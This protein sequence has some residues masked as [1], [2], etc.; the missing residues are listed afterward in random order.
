[1]HS[2][3]SNFERPIPS[4]SWKSILWASL[5]AT[6]AIALAW[7]LYTRSQGY[8]P[9][10]NDSFALWADEREKLEDDS[11]VLIGASRTLFNIDLE[12]LEKG[13]GRKPLQLA[14]TGSSFYPMLE[15]L[16]NDEAFKGTIIIGVVPP[17]LPVPG[18]PL[19]DR[20]KE[21]LRVWKRS[22]ISESI[23]QDIALFLEERIAFLKQEDLTLDILLGK[24]PIANRPNALIA[25]PSPPY[26]ATIERNRRYRMIDACAQPGEL[27]SQVQ[28]TWPPL[29]SP[30]PPPS[31]VDPD[32]F[33]KQMMEAGIAH[34]NNVVNLVR[35]VKDR[36]CKVVFIRHPSSD[37]LR[38]LERKGAPR[39]QIWDPLLERTQVPGIH[40]EDHEELAGF[41]C[42]EWSHLSNED[43]IEYTKRLIPHLKTALQ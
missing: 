26:F 43:S 29:F 2:S 3:T 15:D 42:P 24:L 40:F 36:G 17:M 13:L 14:F 41:P 37:L 9:T 35:R 11:L 25:P 7:E 38:E 27:Q 23:G 10:L 18:G 33:A 30:P 22:T 34:L 12:I 19:M 16:A 8:R 20:P 28:Q 31:F 21:A 6:F 32:V 5:V 4:G 39:E 1:M